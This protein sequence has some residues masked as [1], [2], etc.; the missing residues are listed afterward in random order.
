MPEVNAKVNNYKDIYAES[1]ELILDATWAKRA[2]M[3]TDSDMPTEPD[4]VLRYWSTANSKFTDTR[5]GGSIGINARPQFTP[6]ADI[7]H[8]GRIS[9]RDEV[10]VRS[11]SGDY[12]IGGV[13][14][15]VIDQYSQTIYM[16]FGVPQ[17]NSLMSFM[18]GAVDADAS[19][20]ART[21]RSPTFLYDA[22]KIIGR[23]FVISAFPITSLTI[24]GT[25]LINFF[26]A[27]K[28]SKYYTMKPTMHSYWSAVN[29]LINTLA[30]N[31]GI[32]P[33]VM[34]D[35][36]SEQKTG[37]YVSL[38]RD[39][40]DKLHELM[41]DAFTEQFGYDAFAI[42]SRANRMSIKLQEEDYEAINN[43]NVRLEE[44]GFYQKQSYNKEELM[45]EKFRTFPEWIDH[46]LKFKN[47]FSPGNDANATEF[48]ASKIGDEV[49]ASTKRDS[50]GDKGY[51]DQFKEYYDSEARSGSQ[52]A[53][54]K[55][56]PI[57]SMN[58]SFSNATQESE[59]ANQFNSKSRQFRETR[60]SLADMNIMDL[61]GLASSLK[62]GLTDLASGAIA[63][64]TFNFSEVVM[65]FLGNAYLDIPK[66]WASSTANLSR[67]TYTMRLISPYGNVFSRMQNIFIPLSMILAGALPL[68]TGRT[69]YASPFLCQLYHR[70]IA[71]I[72][73]GMI[74]SLSI[75][76]GACN[77]PFNSRG[78]AMAIDVSFTVVDLSSIMHMPISTGGLFNTLTGNSS[79]LD[80]DNILFDYLAV[81]AGQ[82][83]YSQEYM[84]PRAKLKFAKWLSG[85]QSL[86]SPARMA[87]LV[88]E[89]LTTGNMQWVFPLSVPAKLIDGAVA[90]SSSLKTL[91]TE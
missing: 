27:R 52:F 73:L 42:N 58:E 66:H 48:M 70:G 36:K 7:R 30:I 5:L 21:G 3:V 43:D 71:Q 82:D 49:D 8:K 83:L 88:H 32:L 81:L 10:T 35:E 77:L 86:G 38:D 85:V 55:V 14:S 29:M 61:G 72:Q 18:S 19:R 84:F 1:R 13:Y 2:F 80:E 56:D 37:G 23:V 26:M 33:R 11:T 78:Q 76:R 31:Q 53:I 68:S 44:V 74:E 59:L 62:E 17:F 34:S 16:R 47:L 6:Y 12:G 9:D 54:F 51:F 57:T 75:T 69:S 60:F 65:G 91:V 20:M 40:L 46:M 15:E 64:A 45:G 28:S 90:G 24:M 79:N 39:T 22:G 4:R 25:K 89:S 63:G 41:P 87:S 50:F 67:P